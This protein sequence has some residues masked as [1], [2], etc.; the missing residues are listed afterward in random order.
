VS[1]RSPVLGR[2]ERVPVPAPGVEHHRAV[3]DPH[4]NPLRGADR[5]GLG[6]GVG[7]AVDGPVVGVL[8][9]L[10]DGLEQPVRAGWR[11]RVQ[12]RSRCVPVHAGAG[13]QV[14]G[15]LNR[16]QVARGRPDH[17]SGDVV[18]VGPGANRGA[19]RSRPACRAFSRALTVRWP[20][21][22]RTRPRSPH[23]RPGRRAR[24]LRTAH[25]HG[26]DGPEAGAQHRQ[27]QGAVGRPDQAAA[28]L[29][30][31]WFSSSGVSMSVN[32]H[33]A[34]GCRDPVATWVETHITTSP[35]RSSPWRC[36]LMTRVTTTRAA[37]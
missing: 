13:G 27:G 6:V 18:T 12:P 1:W 32:R 9:A 7:A 19:A 29:A 15:D 31:Q 16:D 2:G 35:P 11:H 33:G 24:S 25:R 23:G 36:S 34:T 3:H 10:Q 37:E 14:V 17:W 5:Q 30:L 4:A 26:V 21:D 28:Q 22:A 20:G 8:P